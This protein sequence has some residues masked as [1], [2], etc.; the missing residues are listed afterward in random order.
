MA[1]LNEAQAEAVQSTEGPVLILAGAGTGKTR[2]VIF[3][4]ANL[5]ERGV[6]PR[7]ILAVTFTNKAACEM[8][9][10]VGEMVRRK[11]AEEM[12]VCTF[13]SL[14]VRI[15]RVHAGLLGYNTN[16]SIAAGGD[17]DGLVKQ[18]IVQHGG[19]KEKIKPWDITAAVSR[20][21]SYTHLTLPT[22]A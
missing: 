7:N 6:D 5:L 2:T 9:E 4:I 3:R 15:L 18:L 22:K 19:A 13:H 17:R 10:R 20:P 8:R 11:A 21:V 16:F 12:T 14:C 1:G